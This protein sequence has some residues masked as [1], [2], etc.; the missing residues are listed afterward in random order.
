MGFGVNDKKITVTPKPVD[1]DGKCWR[2]ASTL[3]KRGDSESDNFADWEVVSETDYLKSTEPAN[4]KASDY[5]NDYAIGMLAYD[6]EAP[7][8]KISDVYDLMLERV[9]PLKI[10]GTSYVLDSDDM[11]CEAGGVCEQPS[12]YEDCSVY[13]ADVVGGLGCVIRNFGVFL[14]SLFVSLFVPPPGP[15]NDAF[16]GLRDTFTSHLGFLIYPITFIGSLLNAFVAY[17]NI[18]SCTPAV[19]LPTFTAPAGII[20]EFSIDL[21]AI[22]SHWPTLW[23]YIKISLTGITVF[24]LIIA[25]YHKYMRIVKA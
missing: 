23:S 13:G 8:P 25:L 19:C 6:C 11:N 5:G 14:R 10:D 21:G 2:W 15:F 22:E 12:P 4:L 9:Y 1:T 3:V 24:G 16:T 20:P 17:D 18:D 7:A